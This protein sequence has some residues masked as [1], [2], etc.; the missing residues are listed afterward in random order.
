VE[1]SRNVGGREKKERGKRGG[2]ER[3]WALPSARRG[4]GGGGGEIGI[5]MVSGFGAHRK[6][7]GKE[8]RKKWKRKNKKSVGSKK[9][10]PVKSSRKCLLEGGGER[11]GKRRVEKE[12]LARPAVITGMSDIVIYDLI[13]KGHKRRGKK[14]KGGRKER[15]EEGGKYVRNFQQIKPLEHADVLVRPVFPECWKKE[16]GKR[17]KKGGGTG[18]WRAPR[19]SLLVGK[20]GDKERCTWQRN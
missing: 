19:P 20:K 8:K 7:A 2:E 11:E 17:K 16:K 18:G 1:S 3:R 13:V 15:G 12:G 10:N 5:A 4:K 6:R 9:E 14:K